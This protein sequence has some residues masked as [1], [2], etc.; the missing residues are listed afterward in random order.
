MKESCMQIMKCA[1]AT[2]TGNLWTFR[3]NQ[4]YFTHEP[5]TDQATKKQNPVV[6]IIYL[7]FKIANLVHFVFLSYMYNGRS[8]SAEV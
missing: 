1:R 4:R 2:E 7:T 6:S 3:L 8:K 5:Y